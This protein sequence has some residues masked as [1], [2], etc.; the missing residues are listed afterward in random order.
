VT[1]AKSFPGFFVNPILVIAD[2]VLFLDG[3]VLGMGLGH[4]FGRDDAAR[5]FVN[6]HVI[7]HKQS[8]DAFATFALGGF[9]LEHPR[10]AWSS[11]AAGAPNTAMIPSAAAKSQR[12]REGLERS[13][14][15]LSPELIKNA[16]GAGELPLVSGPTMWG[17]SPDL[18]CDPPTRRAGDPW[19]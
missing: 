13:S 16:V 14:S 8:Y 15:A 9:E 18:L 17:I 6:V 1:K 7:R 11:N 4:F 3:K 19:I 12:H 2:A 5:K 10:S